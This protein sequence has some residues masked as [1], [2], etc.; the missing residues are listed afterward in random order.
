MIKWLSLILFTFCCCFDAQAVVVQKA[1][2]ALSYK[3][4][5]RMQSRKQESNNYKSQ[6][7]NVDLKSSFSHSVLLNKGD[8]VTIE[9]REEDCCSWK[10]IYDPMVVSYTDKGRSRGIR[11]LLFRQL[12]SGVNST[13]YL[14]SVD[15]NDG[16]T[17]QNKAVSIK[18]N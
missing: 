8:T 5:A 17:K 16:T 1:S 10:A 18:C 13:I 2:D 3:N 12:V 7:H 6:N 14:D 9:V 15:R 11:T 4:V